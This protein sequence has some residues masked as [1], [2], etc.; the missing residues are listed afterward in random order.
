MKTL[1]LVLVLASGTA[2]QSAKPPA[3]GSWTAQFEGRT[4]LELPG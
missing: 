2:G 4:F 1:T 3:A